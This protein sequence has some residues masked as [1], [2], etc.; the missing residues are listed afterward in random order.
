MRAMIGQTSIA[1]PNQIQVRLTQIVK[2]EVVCRND[3]DSNSDINANHPCKG[4][5]V[6]EKAE[7]NRKLRDGCP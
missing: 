3:E 1:L 5:G 7:K 6:I 4:H 2:G